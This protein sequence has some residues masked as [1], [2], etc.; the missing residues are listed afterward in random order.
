MFFFHEGNKFRCFK[1]E[2]FLS[3]VLHQTE[4]L[5]E[6]HFGRQDVFMSN[7][8]IKASFSLWLPEVLYQARITTHSCCFCSQYLISLCGKPEV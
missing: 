2:K 8:P 1:S 7:F 4:V 3:G 5:L 6:L